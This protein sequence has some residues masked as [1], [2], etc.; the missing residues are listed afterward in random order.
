MSRKE[1]RQSKIGHATAES[2]Q[3]SRHRTNPKTRDS[4][5]LI[6]LEPALGFESHVDFVDDGTLATQELLMILKRMIEVS[7]QL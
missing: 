1:P 7:D 6:K 5:S 4:C 2:G 3:S